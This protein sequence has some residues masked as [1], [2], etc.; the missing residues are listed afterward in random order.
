MQTPSILLK[1]IAKAALNYVGLGI[2]GDLAVD[3]LPAMAQDVWKWWCEAQN[4]GERQA[5]LEMLTQMPV[6]KVQA[7]SRSSRY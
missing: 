1:F 6:A 2:A 7:A 5:E 3:V 4:E